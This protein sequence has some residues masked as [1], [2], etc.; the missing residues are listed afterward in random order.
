[1]KERYKIVLTIIITA[2]VCITGTVFATT[3]FDSKD[4][5]YDNTNSDISSD[6]VQDAIDELSNKIEN[7]TKIY[8][9]GDGTTFNIKAL[10]PD[11]YK[12]LTISNFI[13]SYGEGSYNATTGVLTITNNVITGTVSYSGTSPCSCS[14][15][16]NGSACVYDIQPDGNRI[17]RDGP[18]CSGINVSCNSNTSYSGTKEYSKTITPNVWLIV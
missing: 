17:S 16:Y 13:I 3:Y 14:T 12:K 9:L 8:S 11:V 6:N 4:V 10:Y 2:I 7:V 18:L 15:T 1:M 5:G